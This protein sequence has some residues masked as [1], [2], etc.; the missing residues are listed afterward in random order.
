M[1][2]TAVCIIADFDSDHRLFVA[3]LNTPCTKVA[4]YIHRPLKQEKKYLDLLS[5][6]DSVIENKFKKAAVENIQ[7]LPIAESNNNEIND[8]LVKSINTA[9]TDTMPQ[10]EK[11]KVHQ[12]WHDD[13]RLRDLYNLRDKQ[14]AENADSKLIA[15]T[16]KVR[17]RAQYLRDQHFKAEAEKKVRKRAQHLRDQH[18][19]AEAEKVNQ[20]AINRELAKLFSRAKKQE[21]TLKPAP[22]ACPPEKILKHFKAHF[23][24][25]DQS[26][27]STPEELDQNLPNFVKELQNSS[28]SVSI[29]DQPP[30][31]DEIQ[32]RLS[33]MLDV[34]LDVIHRMTTN[35]WEKMDIPDAWGNSRLK[36]LWKGKG[37]KKDPKMHR[38]LIINIILERLRPWYETQLT[39][40]QNGFRKDRGTTD[41]YY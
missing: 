1:F 6:N 8:N 22:E 19:K 10:K 3:H 5:L 14:G 30:T 31:I 27:T 35:L 21:T 32:K 16:K 2:L 9:G 29:N 23:N 40:E 17:K 39:D 41:I 20:H 7:T 28:R 36:T 38:G 24:P 13:E 34:M 4:R 11:T 26:K 15:A 33:V 25:T 37:S 12:P 18:F